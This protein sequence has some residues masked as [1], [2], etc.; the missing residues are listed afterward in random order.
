[1][2]AKRYLTA[3]EAALQLG[4]KEATLYAYVSRGLIRSEAVGDTP[5]QHL[6][7]AEDVQNLLERKVQRR[8]PARA[9]RETLRWGTPILESALTLI[10]GQALYYRGHEV[11]KLAREHTFE[12][13]A[14]LLWAGDMRHAARWFAARPPL[15]ALLP[16]VTGL[17]LPPMQRLQA[18][19]ALAAAEDLGAY[20]LRAEA[21]FYT[22]ARIV[23]LLVASAV[24]REP[25]APTI[26]R[27]IARAWQPHSDTIINAALILC[28]DHEL[29]ASSFTARVVASAEGNPYAVVMAGLAAL[30]GFRHG[31]LTERAA[32][33]LREVPQPEQV[34]TV[35]AER[36][37]RGEGLPGFGHRLY[38]DRDPRAATLLDLLAE[39]YPQAPALVR[40]TSIIQEASRVGSGPPS[41]DFA[42][43]VLEQTLQLPA[44]AGLMIF[45]MGR[46]VGWLAHALE[47]YDGGQ[48]IRPR[49]R[50]NGAPPQS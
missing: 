49:A 21:V 19:L 15:T 18:G 41:I 7:L 1:M 35:I 34:R 20:D 50:Y 25:Q 46:T 32:A 22:A 31:G 30:S 24:Q 37:R 3:K 47:Q 10:T 43:A 17:G 36:L 11:S 12:E 39:A 28:A 44:G 6:Y 23:W 13:V 33:F 9:A 14:A 45:A 38:P 26:A 5:R 16:T 4:V 29:N 40:A 42:L 8:D 27:T 48:L 2:Q